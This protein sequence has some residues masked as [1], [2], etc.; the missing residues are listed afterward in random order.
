VYTAEENAKINATTAKRKETVATEEYKAKQAKQEAEREE[1]LEKTKKRYGKLL[2]GKSTNGTPIPA[3]PL[4]VVRI[5]KIWTKLIADAKNNNNETP[6]PGLVDAIAAYKVEFAAKPKLTESQKKTRR[7]NRATIRKRIREF[8]IK[9]SAARINAYT[10]R[11]NNFKNLKVNN[12]NAKKTLLNY[13]KAEKAYSPVAK[14]LRKIKANAKAALETHRADAEK[15]LRLLRTE[16]QIAKDTG[17]NPASITHLAM[18]RQAKYK[19]KAEDFKELST[20]VKKEKFTEL[21]SHKAMK[22]LI[23]ESAGKDACDRCI[24]NTIF[25]VRVK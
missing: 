20:L 10:K 24:L 4:E 16:A 8:M 17:V 21:T 19:I 7:E 25:G 15:E 5:D 14:G 3:T 12:A 23:A 1:L 13:F 11:R 2:H 6:V 22:A 18:L 9:P